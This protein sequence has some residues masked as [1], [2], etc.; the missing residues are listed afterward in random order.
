MDRAGLRGEGASDVACCLCRE[1]R[2]GR[3]NGGAGVD[4]ISRMFR[5]RPPEVE[6]ARRRA[7]LIA[8]MW[9]AATCGA[10]KM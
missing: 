5:R 1:G 7:V 4:L 6:L 9:L 3:G 8:R 10:A 2:D